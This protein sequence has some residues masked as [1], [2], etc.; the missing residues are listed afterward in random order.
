VVIGIIAVLIAILLPALNKAR[1]SARQVQC[2]SN[3]RQLAQATISFANEHKGYMPGRGGM[4]PLMWSSAS[5]SVSTAPTPWPDGE[6]AWDWIAWQRE[7][8]PLPPHGA[9][10]ADQ[11]ITYSGL[12]KYLGVKA[13]THSNPDEANAIAESLDS[14]FRCPSDNLQQRPKSPAATDKKYRYSYSLNS[15]VG[16][17]SNLEVQDPGWFG[18]T[19]SPTP[20]PKGMRAWGTFTGKISSIKKPGDVLLYVCEDEQSIDD[21]VFSANPFNWDSG[22][23]NAIA[24]RHDLKVKKL[25]GPSGTVLAANKNENGRGNVSFADGHGEFMYRVDALRRKHS[26]NPYPDPTTAPF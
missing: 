14:V 16:T 9:N 2:L 5:H 23:I 24:S 1:E 18:P 4:A 8:D 11:N 22:N 20:R 21:G 7:K 17:T 3:L 6:E 15:N 19:P 10:G 25:R 13:R 12:A 26:G